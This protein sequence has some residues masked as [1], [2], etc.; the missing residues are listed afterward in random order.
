MSSSQKVALSPPSLRLVKPPDPF[1][2]EGGETPS[3]DTDTHPYARLPDAVYGVVVAGW[4]LAPIVYSTRPLREG[5]TEL[6]QD[7]RLFVVGRVTGVAP[8]QPGEAGSAVMRYQETH[9]SRPLLCITYRVAVGVKT[10]TRRIPRR[11][12]LAQLW[13]LIGHRSAGWSPEIADE[14]I[15]WCFHIQTYT[16]VEGRSR[17]PGRKAP[18]R[19]EALQRTWGEEIVEA[20]PPERPQ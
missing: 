2:I 18:H 14:L 19:P 17:K 13:E 9:A 15:G 4:R 8:R 6:E 10:Y 7:W 11:G 3:L 20:R 1:R 16:Q 5:A 12:R